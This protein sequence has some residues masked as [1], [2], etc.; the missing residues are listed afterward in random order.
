MAD[1]TAT[2]DQTTTASNGKTGLTDTIRGA[3]GGDAP[4]TEKFR[5]LYKA[6]PVAT[7][8]LASVAGLAILGSLRGRG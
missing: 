6:R 3:F 8:A 2:N 4:L 7:V 1:L 5:N